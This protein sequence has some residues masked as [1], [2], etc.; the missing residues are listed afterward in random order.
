MPHSATG[1]RPGHGARVTRGD[2]LAADCPLRHARSH[3]DRLFGH[4]EHVGSPDPSPLAGVESAGP[5]PG[6]IPHAGLTEVGAAQSRLHTLVSGA[7]LATA[8]V[9]A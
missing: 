9:Q 2:S 3:G 1:N 8:E 7:L 6:Q 4:D 5:T